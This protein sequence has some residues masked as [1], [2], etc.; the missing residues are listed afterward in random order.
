MSMRFLHAAV[1]FSA[2]L[3]GSSAF[4]VPSPA[5]L[6]KL[7]QEEAE[8]YRIYRDEAH[9]QP[10][11]LRAKPVFN[12]TNVVGEHPQYG[13]LYVWTLGGR[14]EAI[15]TMFSTQTTDTR[16]RK[17][18]HEFHTLS[19]AKL[20]PVTPAT[21][22]YRWEPQKG[23]RFDLAEE[24]PFVA[25]SAGQRLTQM[26]GVARSFAA[27]TRSPPKKNWQLRLLTT[28]L[29][30]Y[31]PDSGEV[32]EGAIFAMVSSAGTDPELL[33]VIE[34]RHPAGDEKSWRWHTAAV[35]FSDV[36][37]IVQ[38]N[39]KP[40][41]SSLEDSELHAEIKNQYTLIETRDKTYMCYQA[42]IIDE[43]PDE[44]PQA[45]RRER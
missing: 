8:S 16:K 42:R 6:Q 44:G 24:A 41:W 40:L 43:L 29:L 38:R 27:E 3:H 11:E 31:Q 28:P 33:L 22:A 26:R 30:Q 19:T 1:L 25:E 12:W 10:L 34:A 2:L 15:G 37:I 14:P 36:D 39:G 4:A 9:T 20:F 32:L 35:R 45:T 7:H 21:S 18:V 13:H 5:A 23:I 17:L